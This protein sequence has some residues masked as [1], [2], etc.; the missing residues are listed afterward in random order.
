MFNP[1][2]FLLTAR[3]HADKNLSTPN[4]SNTS[5]REAT[6]FRISRILGGSTAEFSCWKK[7]PL[8]LCH[9]TIFSTTSNIKRVNSHQTTINYKIFKRILFLN[10]CLRNLLNISFKDMT[11][12]TRFSFR[13]IFWKSPTLTVSL[14]KTFDF[15]QKDFSG[16]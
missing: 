7:Q 6:S 8:L 10:S 11:P 16:K 14:R 1:L 15:F 5:N 2:Y 3:P 9:I 12:A 13:N 4:A